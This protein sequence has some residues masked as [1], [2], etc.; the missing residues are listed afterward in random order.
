MRYWLRGKTAG[1]ICFLLIAV[2]VIGGL[3]W[4]TAEV[5]RLE[6]LEY[7]ATARMDLAHRMRLALWRLDTRVFSV[8]AKESSRPYHDYSAVYAP[9]LAL[10]RQGQ[11][12]QCGRVLQPSPLLYQDL[13]DWVVLHFQ[14]DANQRLQCPQVLSSQLEQRLV[15]A[16]APLVNC[17]AERGQAFNRLQWGLSTGKLVAQIQERQQDQAVMRTSDLGVINEVALPTSQ[18]EQLD[19][20]ASNYG[21]GNAGYGKGKK[22]TLPEFTKRL[23]R[24]QEVQQS[25]NQ[26]VDNPDNE[27]LLNLTQNGEAWFAG[28][29]AAAESSKQVEVTI[30]PMVPVWVTLNGEQVG[31]GGQ[32]AQTWSFGQSQRG[33]GFPEAGGASQAQQL[34]NPLESQQKQQRAVRASGGQPQGVRPPQSVPQSPQAEPANPPPAS[35]DTPERPDPPQGQPQR[36]V[37]NQQGEAQQDAALPRP[38]TGAPQ[39]APIQSPGNPPP[40][41]QQEAPVPQQPAALDDPQTS[42]PNALPPPFSQQ[43]AAPVPQMRGEILQNKLDMPRTIE[44]P[45]QALVVARLVEVGGQQVCQGIL[46]DWDKLRALLLEEVK[47]LF[48]EVTLEPVREQSPAFPERTMAALPVMMDPG[49]LNVGEMPLLTPLRFGLML[50]WSAAIVALGVVAAGGW[51]LLDLSERRIRFVSTVTH[52]LRTPLTTLRLYLDM[53][54][55][56]MVKEEEAKNEYLHT[57]NIEADRLNRLI[58]NVLDFSRLE[59][60]RPQLEW[61]DVP[62]A[63]MLE[64]V[65]STWEQRCHDLGKELV[66]ENACRESLSVHTD[67]RLVQ[68]ILANLI[69]NACKYSRDAEDSRIWLRATSDASGDVRFEVEDCGPGVAASKRRAIFRPFSRLSGT[70]VVVGGVGLGLALAQRWARLLRGELQV[71]SGQHSGGA[72]FQLVLPHRF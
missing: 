9:T 21:K 6:R 10:D 51:A 7:E 58:G 3:G 69:D 70:D 25:I 5:L 50:A 20:F 28:A 15:H 24:N 62:V 26:V 13:P 29:Q 34:H 52:E 18:A 17:N 33:R 47:D 63:E 4:V 1:G 49:P 37:P 27:L 72:C 66:V 12:V 31:V 38:T 44:G 45:E 68:Q 19:Q 39:N 57:L 40:P 8:L 11:A 59:N 43:S 30:G 67:P 2:L 41:A 56:G 23:Q 64:N 55:S 42:P 16:A 60:Q 53:L 46:L 36:A 61:E 71:H 65:R 35:P 32:P 14:V 22:P 48:P 54:S